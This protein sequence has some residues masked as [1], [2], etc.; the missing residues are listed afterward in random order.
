M[1]KIRREK[2]IKFEWS[3]TINGEVLPLEGENIKIELTLPS[4][5]KRELPFIPDG[6]V[7]KFTYM[8]TM[9]GDYIL[10]AWLIREGEQTAL[11]VK[12][13]E[14]VERTYEENNE[15]TDNLQF[16]TVELN[17]N[18]ETTATEEMVRE[19]VN[20]YTGN[21]SELHTENKSSIVLAINE[22]YDELF[23]NVDGGETVFDE[24]RDGRT[25]R[26]ITINYE[27]TNDVG[28]SLCLP[29]D[30]NDE[31]LTEIFGENYKLGDYNT[32]TFN[33][34]DGQPHMEI[35]LISQKYELES[36]KP[37]VIIP[38][39]DV[40]KIVVRDKTIHTTTTPKVIT[41][42]EWKCTFSGEFVKQIIHQS[43]PEEHIYNYAISNGIWKQ[44]LG[45]VQ[46]KGY[47]A[48]LNV[49]KIS[50]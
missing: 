5:Q 50:N 26:K 46:L 45:N 23:I 33:D 38:R 30:L 19:I 13:F 21:L 11:D 44:P 41:S 32:F 3:L 27:M 20:E 43:Q 6:N 1:R 42:G 49:S 24:T 9:L 37:Y 35:G 25:Y 8:G 36:G 47:R 7:A 48:F 31:E 29:F 28:K 18:F 39:K 17:G 34:D 40:S 16:E 2:T 14:L 22:I 4:K 15:T 12:G 10:T